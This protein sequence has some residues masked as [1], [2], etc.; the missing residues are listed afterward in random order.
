MSTSL[1]PAAWSAL[2]TVSMILFAIIWWKMRPI[3]WSILF[4]KNESI[5]LSDMYVTWYVRKISQNHQITDEDHELGLVYSSASRYR[6]VLYG[7]IKISL[8]IWDSL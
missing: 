1:V 8:A 6:L 3:A 5:L 2:G 4:E 7:E